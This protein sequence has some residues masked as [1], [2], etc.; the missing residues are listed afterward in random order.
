MDDAGVINLRVAI[1]SYLVTNHPKDLDK[2]QMLFLR[3]HMYREI[4]ENLLLEANRKLEAIRN[5]TINAES[6]NYLLDIMQNFLDAAD[7]FSKEKCY[8]S[9]NS[10]LAMGSLIALQIQSPDSK[11]I[12]LQDDEVAQ[13]MSFRGKFHDVFILA[14]AYKRNLLSNWIG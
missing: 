7:N 13:L 14:T 10:C 11:V 4:A 12:N 6:R 8:V 2:L 1:H 3:F 9:A 5:K